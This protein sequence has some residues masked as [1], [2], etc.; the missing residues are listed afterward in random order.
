[1]AYMMG[2]RGGGRFPSKIKPSDLYPSPILWNK[3]IP[4]D[5]AFRYDREYKK[6]GHPTL[7]EL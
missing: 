3:L 7:T 6:H 4:Y 5:N 2:G 1:M